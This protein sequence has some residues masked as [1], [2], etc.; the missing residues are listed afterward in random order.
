MT[1]ILVSQLRS[2]EEALKELDQL[3]ADRYGNC[4]DELT[5]NGAAECINSFFDRLET[6]ANP[7]TTVDI[8]QTFQFNDQQLTIRLKHPAPSGMFA[9]VTNLFRWT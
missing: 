1:E 6:L 5:Y 7:G 4:V 8:R 2:R 3:I 9:K